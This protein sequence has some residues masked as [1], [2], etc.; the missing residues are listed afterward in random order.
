MQI[1]IAS[2][3]IPDYLD[4]GMLLAQFFMSM[5][6][7]FLPILIVFLFTL[8]AAG[9][10]QVTDI[11]AVAKHFASGDAQKMSSYFA[12]AI[13]LNVFSEENLYSRSQ[14]EQILRD[15]FSKNRP[16]SVKVIHRLT[17]NSN[18]R[19]AVLSMQTAKDKF[20]VTISMSSN[21]ERF[22]V[23][24]IRIEYDKE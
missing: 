18:Y 12:S 4:H 23:K 22:L 11:D 2:S 17:S 15:F 24:E 20:R 16:V 9:T 5:T 8:N 10:R 6:R 1:Y 21:G 19:L 7:R 14:A 13:E 3:K